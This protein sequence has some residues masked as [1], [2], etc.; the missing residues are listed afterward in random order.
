MR[1]T[2]FYALIVLFI[3]LIIFT[4]CQYDNY[5]T[6]TSP[7]LVYRH[8]IPGVVSFDFFQ[9]AN[10]KKITPYTNYLKLNNMD[11]TSK[12]EFCIYV[13]NK[14][15]IQY[16]NLQFSEKLETIDGVNY[17]SIVLPNT[18]FTLND[19]NTIVGILNLN[20]NTHTFSGAYEG[21]INVN[22][23][24]SNG[25]ETFSRSFIT[26]GF[27]DY[28]G[29]FHFLTDSRLSEEFAYISGLFNSDNKFTASV[30]NQSNNS[31]TVLENGD[32]P[33]KIDK[34]ILRGSM[35][36]PKDENTQSQIVLEFNLSKTN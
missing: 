8:N 6:P 12:M 26:H 35:F 10:G 4:N 23:M 27:V 22:N 20:N 30:N 31:S 34:N 1:E 36:L 21:E 25:E 14:N 7:P 17:D 15:S 19:T 29:K 9:Y 11:D 5:E 3:P 33:F 13:F 28:H 32:S 16:T 18:N 2:K 24:S